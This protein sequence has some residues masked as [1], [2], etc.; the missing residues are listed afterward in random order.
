MERKKYTLILLI[1]SFSMLS[2]T[3]QNKSAIYNA[4]IHN[5]MDNWKTVI[6]KMQL[7]T[8]PSDEFLFELINY[9]YGYIAW[10]IGNNEKKQAKAY[11][12]L[13]EDNLAELEKRSYNSSYINAYK[14]AFYGFNVGL[15]KL[16]A[17]FLGPKS[18][19]AAKLSMQEDASNPNGFI[20]FGNA[21]FYMPPIF[22]GS[23]SEALKYYQQAANIME[24]NPVSIKNDWNYLSLLVNIAEAYNEIKE[25]DKA[26][27]Y[28]RRILEIEP[29]FK[30]VK[31]ELYPNFIK[32]RNDE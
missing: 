6:D 28:Y 7:E 15:N 14:S 26:E 11:L 2:L 24:E 10:C 18:V 9:Q 27:E 19:N 23:K 1:F 31:N 8:N 12:K 5:Q 16:K 20:Q 25:Y 29:D 13:A 32:K 21:Q 17:P 22:G 3:A 4:Y 30:W